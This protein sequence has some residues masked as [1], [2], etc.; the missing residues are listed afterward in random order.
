MK[1]ALFFLA[2]AVLPTAASAQPLT[3]RMGESWAFHVRN[4]EPA[5]A[6]KIALVTKPARGEIKAT[7]GAMAGATMTLTNN[8][9][10]GYTYRADLIGSSKPTGRTC[11]LPPTNQPTLEYWPQKASAIRLSDFR[12]AAKGGSCP[13]NR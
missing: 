8:T 2:L 10:I 6:H 13:Q 9:G 11:T 1:A 3:I 7:V 4:G 5:E 12:P